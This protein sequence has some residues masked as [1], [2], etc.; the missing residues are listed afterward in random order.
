MTPETPV[1]EQPDELESRRLADALDAVDAG[2]DPAAIDPRED[3]EL[4]ALME[5]VRLLREI[6][7]AVG[8]EQPYAA[9]SRA[10][11]L[12]AM[13]H[14][15]SRE[16]SREPVEQPASAPFYRRWRWAILTPVATAATAAAITFAVMTFASPTDAPG[17]L[18]TQLPELAVAPTSIVERLASIQLALDEID[19]R[20][21][22]GEPI[23]ISLLR[24]VTESTASVANTIE[25]DPD[26]LAE[27]IVATYLRTAYTSQTVLEAADAI[28]GGEGAL[29]A[30]QRAAEDGFDVAADYFVATVQ[31]R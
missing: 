9:R 22:R 20:N 17:P 7:A 15:G 8:P 28:E 19:E 10:M 24:A 27:E 16:G 14:S 26:T 5:T 6:T 30:A 3:P 29:A 13:E 12:H 31:S 23:E 11:I 2:H 1:T 4:A 18:T 25:A 21:A